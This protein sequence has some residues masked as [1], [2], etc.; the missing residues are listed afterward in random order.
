[1]RP[2]NRLDIRHYQRIRTT[3]KNL[4][5]HYLR[6][7]LYLRV[8]SELADGEI[9]LPEVHLFTEGD[10]DRP[11]TW[12]MPKPRCGIESLIQAYEE[13]VEQP[14]GLVRY[15]GVVIER[16]LR[17][18]GATS[19]QG[20][21]S[22]GSKPENWAGSVVRLLAL[23]ATYPGA[24]ANCDLVEHTYTVLVDGAV[25]SV[26]KDGC[27]SNLRSEVVE[28]AIPAKDIEE[29]VF[30]LPAMSTRS[31]CVRTLATLLKG[32]RDGLHA[33]RGLQ[34]C[35][36]MQVVTITE[37]HE[38]F[39]AM[40]QGAYKRNT[41]DRRKHDNTKGVTARQ[42]ALDNSIAII[43]A[44]GDEMFKKLYYAAV[45]DL[46]SAREFKS[47]FGSPF[48]RR[49]RELRNSTVEKWV[50]RLMSLV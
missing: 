47:T 42:S 21:F 15:P 37:V 18:D 12:L 19:V 23:A 31:R 17:Q 28:A 39:S 29:A 8:Y 24:V 14:L 10:K 33:V 22:T 34:E 36:D 41:P 9:D 45:P 11:I 25:L 27:Y 6:T 16:G 44:G 26:T 48:S 7:Q 30:L 43:G 46:M 5:R 1:M 2:L 40:V 32:N 13:F 35:I 49:A 50:E 38:F 3:I 20:R 4:L